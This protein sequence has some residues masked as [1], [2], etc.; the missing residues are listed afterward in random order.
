MSLSLLVANISV[1]VAKWACIH[2]HVKKND[3]EEEEEE[4]LEMNSRLL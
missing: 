4:N 1:L 3:E 2:V